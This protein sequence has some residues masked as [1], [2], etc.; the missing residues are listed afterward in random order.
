MDTEIAS[1][2]STIH[3]GR[4]GMQIFFLKKNTKNAIAKAYLMPRKKIKEILKNKT[5]KFFEVAGSIYFL[6]PSIRMNLKYQKCNYDER[7][8]P[9]EMMFSKE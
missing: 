9:S 7:G 6:D 3:A 1:D 5:G 4:H 2:E 8:K